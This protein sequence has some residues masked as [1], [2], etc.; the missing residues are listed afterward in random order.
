MSSLNRRQFL[1]LITIAGGSA[2]IAIS[3]GCST[4]SSG[5]SSS[6][7]A[8]AS[9]SSASSNAAASGTGL[10]ASFALMSDVHINADNDTPTTRF[11]NALEQ[12]AAMDTRPDAIVV[13]G[14]LTDNGQAKQYAIFKQVVQASSFDLDDFIIVSGNHDQYVD[15]VDDPEEFESQHKLLIKTFDLPGL[16]Y[17]TKVAGQHFIIMGPDGIID[18]W[19]NFKATET[20][21]NWLDGLLAADAKAG[22]NS[23]IV[24]HEPICST[25]SGSYEGDWGYVNSFVNSDEVLAVVGKYPHAVYISGHTHIFPAVEA[26]ENEP[27]YVTDGSCARSYKPGEGFDQENPQSFGIMMEVYSDHLTFHTRNFRDNEWDGEPLEVPLHK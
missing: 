7:S 9:S 1:K 22:V 8:S 26:D 16:Y 25:I 4:S 24:C 12:I 5:T 27:I 14:D 17:D 21:L 15:D 11:K 23:F 13:A 18:N 19:C 3:T 10:L 2:A 6:A 20:Q